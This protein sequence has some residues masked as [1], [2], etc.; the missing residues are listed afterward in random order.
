MNNDCVNEKRMYFNGNEIW[1]TLELRR[2]G[3]ALEN[4]VYCD[5]CLFNLAGGDVVTESCT[6]MTCG[7]LAC[8]EC[9]QQ[10]ELLDWH[11]VGNKLRMCARCHYGSSICTSGSISRFDNAQSMAALLED[12]LLAS[13][14]S[15]MALSE[16]WERALARVAAAQWGSMS[17]SGQL[18]QDEEQLFEA[19]KALLFPMDTRQASHDWSCAG[20]L[21]LNPAYSSPP[22][23]AFIGHFPSPFFGARLEQTSS[24]SSIVV[25]VKDGP[26]TVYR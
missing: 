21:K 24:S 3:S 7:H 12:T 8:H 6:H 19:T 4:C 18:P 22:S 26:Y 11:S 25:Y 15:S 1:R 16:L 14:Q 9:F 20:I 5:R 17:M 13:G 23:T 10:M 2:S